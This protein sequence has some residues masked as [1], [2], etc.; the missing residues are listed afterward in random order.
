MHLKVQMLGGG[1]AGT[2]CQSYN[3]PCLHLLSCLHQVL[4]L[5]AVK[6]GQPIGMADDDAVSIAAIGTAARHHTSEGGT[7]IIVGFG[8]QVHSRVAAAPTIR[9]NHLASRQWIG[10][11]ARFQCR[12]VEPHDITFLKGVGI[13]IL[14]A[15]VVGQILALSTHVDAESFLLDNHAL[16]TQ[17]VRTHVDQN[18]RVHPAAIHHDGEKTEHTV[19]LS[20]HNGD[21]LSGLHLVAHLHQ[22]LGVMSVDRLKAVVMSYHDHMAKLRM[23]ARDAHHTSKHGFHGVAL[24]RYDFYIVAVVHHRGLSH[25][26]GKRIF[27]VGQTVEVDGEH[28]RT[29]KQVFCLYTDLLLFQRRKLLL[30]HSISACRKASCHDNNP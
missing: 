18:L 28:I 21:G 23:V 20:A 16:G 15:I 19:V 30:R 11:F 14:H 10:P 13:G 3:L 2:P 4:A 17:I 12:E 6:G 25:G 22:V 24:G 1:P 9:T 8:L 29:L 26:Q 27:L 7:D 5:V